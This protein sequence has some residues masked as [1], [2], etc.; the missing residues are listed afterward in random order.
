MGGAAMPPRHWL[1][2]GG[3]RRQVAGNLIS[4][5]HLLGSRGRHERVH[6]VV[7]VDLALIRAVPDEAHG[8]AET[9]ISVTD[10]RPTVFLTR[11]Q[12]AC[13]ANAV[14]VIA[15]ADNGQRAVSLIGDQ[16][17]HLCGFHFPA[18]RSFALPLDRLK[19]GRG[20]QRAKRTFSPLV[21]PEQYVRICSNGRT[22]SIC[23]DSEGMDHTSMTKSPFSVK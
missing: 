10:D 1:C 7:L 19:F 8:V 17:D 18:F 20:S 3:E 21:F 13:A 11:G 6:E 23:S 2:D 5:C 4:P 15:L 9:I 22:I 12:S 16:V 14:V